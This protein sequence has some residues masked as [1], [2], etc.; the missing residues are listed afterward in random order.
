MKKI[1]DFTIKGYRALLNEGLNAGYKFLSFDDPLKKKY[2]KVCLLRHDIDNNLNLALKMA[3]IEKSLGIR[4]TY[5]FMLR[6]PSY[7]LFTKTNYKIV[8]KIIQMNH[9][10]GLHY[11]EISYKGYRNIEALIEKE[12]EVISSLFS[13]KMNIVSIHQPKVHILNGKFKTS[14][15]TN[16]YDKNKFQDFRYI[17]DSN[18]IWKDRHPYHIFKE[19]IYPR[20]QLLI[21]PMWWMSEK[22]LQ[23]PQI[24]NKIILSNL[25]NMQK[26]LL[27]T[28]KAFGN[29]RKFLVKFQSE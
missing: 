10:V 2:P 22:N 16:T 6:S 21:H 12:I 1:S 8:K 20:I 11:H 25:E 13:I 4:A 27:L 3:N 24:W 5:L 26:E 15:F 29:K 19:V 28:E 18:K 14:K 17:S 23:T 9:W 7:N